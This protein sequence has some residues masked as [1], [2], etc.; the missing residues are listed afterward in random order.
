MK[1]RSFDYGIELK[2]RR[3]SLLKELFRKTIHLLSAFVPLF[4]RLNYSVTIFLLIFALIMY[5]VCEFLRLK[6]VEVPVVSKITEVASRKRDE[7]KFVLGPV[8][9]VIGI[10]ICSLLWKENFMAVKIGIFSLSFGDGLASLFG[11][12][13]GKQK[14]PFAQGKTACGSLACFAAVYI[15]SFAVC[16]NCL[17][18]FCF[19][20][21]AMIL[22]IFPLKDLDNILIPVMLGGFAFFLL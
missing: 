11:K 15:S 16:Q 3:N 22:E 1:Q 4:L 7:N 8:T 12:L 13:F 6:G 14:I 21:F 10:L 20:F 9:L 19:A 17:Y 18:S 5:S 2:K